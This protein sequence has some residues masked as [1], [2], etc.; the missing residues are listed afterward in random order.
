MSSFWVHD[1]YGI[2]VHLYHLH[3]KSPSVRGCCLSDTLILVF[4]Y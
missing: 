2:V 1:V 4:S 3:I